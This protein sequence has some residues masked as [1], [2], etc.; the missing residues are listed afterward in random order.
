MEI[1][2]PGSIPDKKYMGTCS[3]CGC[4]AQFNRSEGFFLAA[5][6]G[7]GV[8]ATVTIKCPTESCRG[9]IHGKEVK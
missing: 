6:P 8:E 3:N 5:M 7:C 4:V 9:Y 2:T 1:I